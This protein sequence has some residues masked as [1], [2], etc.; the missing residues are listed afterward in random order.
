MAG[1]PLRRGEK[2]ICGEELG[3]YQILEHQMAREV[4]HVLVDDWI[5]NFLPVVSISY[6]SKTAREFGYYGFNLFG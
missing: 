1:Q 5:L 3:D 2:A 6:Q 4:G